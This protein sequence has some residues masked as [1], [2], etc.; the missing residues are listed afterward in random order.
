MPYEEP[1]PPTDETQK[2][3]NEDQPVLFAVTRLMPDSS[4]IALAELSEQRCAVLLNVRRPD[5]DTP[6]QRAQLEQTCRLLGIRASVG[7]NLD[8]PGLSLDFA[9]DLIERFQ[10]RRVL[11]LGIAHPRVGGRNEFLPPRLYQRTGEALL[12]AA[13]R[14]RERGIDLDLDCGFVPCMFSEAFFEVTGFTAGQIGNRCGPIP[15]V[16]PDLSTIHCYALG[17]L[18]RYP[19]SGVATTAELLRWHADRQ[20]RFRRLG[21]YRACSACNWRQTGQ[22]CG[23]CLATSLLRLR[24]RDHPA[25][26]C[27]RLVRWSTPL[28]PALPG[29]TS[30]EPLPGHHRPGQGSTRI[31]SC[32]LAA[33]SRSEAERE[34]LLDIRDRRLHPELPVF[35][36][37]HGPKCAVYL[38]GH[39]L[40]LDP[41]VVTKL[42]AYWRGSV[43]DG[44]AS[45]LIPLART[46]QEHAARAV[47]QWQT[48][49]VR[50]FQPEC[51]NLQLAYACNLAC[52]YCYTSSSRATSLPNQTSINYAAVIA[53][54]DA[55]AACCADL[56]KPFHFVVQGL[57]EPTLQW[58]ALQ[59]CVAEA[60]TVAARRALDWYGH[61][62]T[63]GQFSEQQAA[64]LA[65][66]FQ[67]ISLSCDGPPEVQD[68]Q[69]PRLDGGASSPA[70][71]RAA[72]TLQRL[73]ADVEVRATIT[74]HLVSRM[75]ALVQ[76]GS[77]VLVEWGVRFP[78]ELPGRN[79]NASHA[80]HPRW[81]RWLPIA[82]AC[83]CW[84]TP[85][86]RCDHDASVRRSG[87][88]AAAGGSDQVAVVGAGRGE[89]RVLATGYGRG[90]GVRWQDVDQQRLRGWRETRA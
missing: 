13:R 15:D 41:Q 42:E 45:G 10:L 90:R 22:C 53:A 73:G 48:Q 12:T 23:G 55:V 61:I 83:C 34:V 39:A 27:S 63:N 79:S 85:D 89:D 54:A 4:R 87:W 31:A 50:V 60:R 69:R 14:A 78:T 6:D 24:T 57:G 88:R 75:N 66:N 35:A 46:L 82:A 30:S 44:A 47:R 71:E 70:L 19:L 33:H 59:R 51:L 65:E 18:D 58:H 43:S 21:L 86:R 56:G 74:P 72:E 49:R 76:R 77:E 32:T 37:E 11:R 7:V 68:H 84:G 62:T 2:P 26:W 67:S 17:N 81:P 9:F 40:A 5:A 80:T 28:V 20:A 3:P 25:S 8:R 52:A 36:L 16:L 29:D 38:P 1:R 64:W